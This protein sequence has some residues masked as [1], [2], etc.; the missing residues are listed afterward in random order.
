MKREI[1]LLLMLFFICSWNW[2]T[3]EEIAFTLYQSLNPEL[4]E[5]L[6]L[7]LLVNGSI[8]PDKVFRDN[9]LHH[10]PPSLNKSMHYMN[11]TEYNLDKG[12]YENASYFLG[13]L[14][15]YIS[16]SFVA[17]HNIKKETS[18]Q[19]SKFEKNPGSVRIKCAKKGY[20]LNESLYAGSLNSKDWGKWL[21]TYDKEIP[22]K[23]LDEAMELVFSVSLDLLNTTCYN[24][25]VVYEDRKVKPIKI[26][27]LLVIIIIMLVVIISL[28]K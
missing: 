20:N 2:K 23:E 21:N 13:V 18:E 17:P 15:H 12:D 5:K 24:P 8:A 26:I 25:E 11:L 4:K 9:V 19:H 28:F 6:D 10:Y 7:D 14:T 22:N 27:A 16:D 3:H 1:F